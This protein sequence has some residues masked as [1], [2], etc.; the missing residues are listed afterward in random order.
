MGVGATSVAKRPSLILS[1]SF[2]EPC[3]VQPTNLCGKAAPT[4]MSKM[5]PIKAVTEHLQH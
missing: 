3:K 5:S 1:K 4:F 2:F